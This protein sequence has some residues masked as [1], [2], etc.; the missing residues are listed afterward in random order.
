MLSMQEIADY[1]R[2]FGHCQILVVGDLMVDEYLWGHIERISPEAPVPILKIVRS[3]S[4]LGGAGNVVRNLRAL[5]V[6][7]KVC[8][9]VGEDETGAEIRRLIGELAVDTRG[10]VCDPSRKSTR[11]VRLMSLE[12]GQQV[13]RMD[14]ETARDA[15]G[16]IEDQLIA[17]IEEAAFGTHAILCSDYLKGVLTKRVLDFVFGLARTN[18]IAS[19]VGP[20]DSNAKKYRGASILMP[21]Q[22]E[23]AQLTQTVM[24]GNGWLTDSSRRLVENLELEA[25]VVTR[26][27]EGMS[28]FEK[29]A[30]GLRR[31]DI[32][33]MA[34]SVYDVTGAGDTAISVLAAT[35]ASRASLSSAVY[36]ANLAAGIK[37]GKRGTNTVT[38]AEIHQHLSDWENS[39]IK[40]VNSHILPQ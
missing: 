33:T 36:L 18:S 8:G 26:G 28:L 39:P 14:E 29:T 19:L 21:N 20:K 22:R 2:N 5:G 30:Q 9:I 7:V 38:I 10:L 27:G 37:V 6:G 3:E 23:L 15:S 13:F 40:P 17:Q 25:L 16:H 4:T 11:K 12:H 31:V 34:K 32:P 24:D 35:I 1:A